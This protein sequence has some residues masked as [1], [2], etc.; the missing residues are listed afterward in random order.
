MVSSWLAGYLNSIW[1]RKIN[2]VSYDINKN[3]NIVYLGVLLIVS[4]LW[5]IPW[6]IIYKYIL[7]FSITHNTYFVIHP[8]GTYSFLYIFVFLL[9]SLVMAHI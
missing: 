9:N 7:I 2:T 8:Y 5:N 4:F 3:I 1:L 6:C